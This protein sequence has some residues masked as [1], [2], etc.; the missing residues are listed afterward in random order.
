MRRAL[1]VVLCGASL[2]AC[3][4]ELGD[5]PGGPA[6]TDPPPIKP[7]ACGVA[8]QPG[9]AP[10]LVAGGGSG[11]FK[12]G[13]MIDFPG[14]VPHNNLLV[15]LLNARGVKATTFGDPAY[16]TGPLKELIG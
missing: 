6:S 7:Q 1:I 5:A 8:V 16:C 10:F 14:D 3:V 4:G 15:S 13:R 2:A 9:P 12:M 11:Y